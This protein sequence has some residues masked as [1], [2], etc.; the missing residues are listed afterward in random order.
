MALFYC[1]ISLALFYCEI[2]QLFSK[3]TLCFGDKGKWQNLS[4]IFTAQ[5]TVRDKQR[6]SQYL[7]WFWFFFTSHI[8][9][10]V[11]RQLHHEH[12]TE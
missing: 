7:V 4:S 2:S 11:Y 10:G 6:P 1:E 12:N 5:S 8:Y 3:Q 9:L